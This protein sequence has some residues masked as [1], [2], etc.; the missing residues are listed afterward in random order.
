L[1][2]RKLS[3]ITVQIGLTLCELRSKCTV[4]EREE[5]V[6]FVDLLAFIEMNFG[7]LTIDTGLDDH[8]RYRLHCVP[9]VLTRMGAASS[10]ATAATTVCAGAGGAFVSAAVPK[11]VPRKKYPPPMNANRRTKNRRRFIDIYRWLSRDVMLMI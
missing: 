6:S 8:S 4:V 2:P 7:D 5:N 1:S 11:K 10:V 9:I 3:T